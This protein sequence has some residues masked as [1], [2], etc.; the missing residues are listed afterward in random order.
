MMTIEEILARFDNRMIDDKGLLIAEI[1]GVITA[2]EHAACLSGEFLKLPRVIGFDDR[3]AVLSKLPET[4]SQPWD[5]KMD[6]DSVHGY[7]RLQ[8]PQDNERAARP[9]DS[10]LVKFER[11]WSSDWNG[12]EGPIRGM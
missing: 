4:G 10:P 8:A 11:A 7:A 1:N 6:H 9:S 12:P 3:K 5:A 2:E